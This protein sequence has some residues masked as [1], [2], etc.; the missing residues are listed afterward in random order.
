[1][2]TEEVIRE[3]ETKA[4]QAIASVVFDL[5]GPAVDGES[6]EERS[7]RYNEAGRFLY[8][9][10][11]GIAQTRAALMATTAEAEAKGAVKQ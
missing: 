1:M 6:V 2:I 4:L 8:E 3:C 9:M 10:F 7:A 5:A 11:L